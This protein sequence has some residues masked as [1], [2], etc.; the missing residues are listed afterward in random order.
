MAAD[1]DI[2]A[3]PATRLPLAAAGVHDALDEREPR[4]PV[5]ESPLSRR[6]ILDATDECLAQHGYDG[7]TIRRI[8]GSMQCAVG[9]I[10]R[11]FEDKRQLLEAVTQRRFDAV[12]ADAEA[13]K[14]L[15]ANVLAYARQAADDAQAYRLMF[16]LA[17]MRPDALTPA[18]AM[19]GVVRRIIA[20][21][22]RQLGDE[23]RA[24]R[25]WSFVHGAAMLGRDPQRATRDA[26]TLMV[27]KAVPTVHIRVPERMPA[28]APG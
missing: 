11:Y 21:W 24:Q 3:G 18:E 7:T 19:P 20:A 13:G 12:A 6:Q 15:D 2:Q 8:A 5:R 9:S 1:T 28:I 25:L 17:S 14:P 4:R 27:R 23:D 10:Y 22:S 26:E 16:W